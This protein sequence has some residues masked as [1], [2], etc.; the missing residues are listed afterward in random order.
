MCSITE[1]I[2]FKLRQVLNFL[3]NCRILDWLILK[4]FANDNRDV[5]EKT[6]FILACV[7]NFVGKG[8]NGGHYNFFKRLL[9][10]GCL[11][12]GKQ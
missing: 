1:D 10:Q 7:E 12:S 4:V 8:E 9:F 3:P 6:K 2:Y 5:T 11:K